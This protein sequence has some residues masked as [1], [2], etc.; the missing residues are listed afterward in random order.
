SIPPTVAAY[1]GMY[2][3]I[4]LPVGSKESILIPPDALQ[5]VG[6]L[7]MVTVVENGITR[8]RSVKTG[9]AYPG[10]IEVLSGLAP[11]EQIVLP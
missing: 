2:G 3:K 1:P 7:E 4:R 11:G 6:Q 9:K 8:V 10:G 5:R